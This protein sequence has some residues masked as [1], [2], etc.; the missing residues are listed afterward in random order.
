MLE[1]LLLPQKP[2]PF[3]VEQKLVEIIAALDYIPGGFMTQTPRHYLIWL[4]F[5]STAHRA[6]DAFLISFGC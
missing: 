6:T 5:S 3:T 4:G 2:W 1:I